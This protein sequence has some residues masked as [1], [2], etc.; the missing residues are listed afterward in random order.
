[1]YTEYV[2][3]VLVWGQFAK[4]FKSFALDDFSESLPVSTIL[5]TLLTS[6]NVW[7]TIWKHK[8]KIATQNR[9][10]A[11]TGKC[12]HGIFAMCHVREDFDFEIV[13]AC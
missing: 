13:Y 2:A 10:I 3:D 8:H 5:V 9:V 4:K 6:R 12:P 1:M 11:L 7:V